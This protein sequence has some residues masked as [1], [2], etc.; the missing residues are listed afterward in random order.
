[1]SAPEQVKRPVDESTSGAG[2]GAP[3]VEAPRITLPTS[4]PVTQTV[5]P[6][7]AVGGAVEQ[8]GGT[9]QQV[10]QVVQETLP[11]VAEPVTGA[12]G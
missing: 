4:E 2:G 10:Q 6:I 7:G 11:K 1:V 3:S 9:V 5:D 8:G 12:L